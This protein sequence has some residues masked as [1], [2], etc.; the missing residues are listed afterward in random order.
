MG[1]ELNKNRTSFS[2]IVAQPKF[3]RTSL[4]SNSSPME[5]E[6]FK[7]ERMDASSEKVLMQKIL[8]CVEAQDEVLKK[9]ISHLSKIEEEK[10]E[11]DKDNYGQSK[12]TQ[13]D[14]YYMMTKGK[15]CLCLPNFMPQLKS[16]PRPWTFKRTHVNDFSESGDMGSWEDHDWP[17]WT[18]KVGITQVTSACFMLERN[19]DLL[20][21]CIYREL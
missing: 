1:H 11:E 7:E 4:H 20:D 12:P 9:M 15:V 8:K 14:N 21:S 19:M 2:D 5:G 17:E 16:T 18:S 6:T 13:E 10:D 3:K